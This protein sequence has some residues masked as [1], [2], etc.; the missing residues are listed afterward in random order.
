[1]TCT[2]TVVVDP[3]RCPSVAELAPQIRALF[4]RG[5]AWSLDPASM[6][7]RFCRVLATGFSELEARICAL[8]EEFWCATVA[9]TRPEWMAEYG[10][11]DA[12]DPYPDLCSKVAATGGATCAYLA[13][14]A[15][16]AGW[17]IRCVEASAGLCG[18][19]VGDL[20][21]GCDSVGMGAT[22]GTLL[23]EVELA[24]SR[25]YVAPDFDLPRLGAFQVG[26]PLG[27]GPDIGPLK[28]LI[29][30]ITHAH[31][32]VAYR[33][34]SPPVYLAASDSDLLATDGNA[35][36]LAENQ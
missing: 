13:A 30:R 31:L 29:E 33:L 18:G 20:S 7:M 10:L 19:Q 17:S 3:D 21:V 28:C 35:F 2:S 16:V 36:I 12:C 9:E 24:E 4:P 11:P 15:A 5:R 25:A 26:Q 1:M 27:C 23:I 34:L 22:A 8:R 32:V 6:L 14:R